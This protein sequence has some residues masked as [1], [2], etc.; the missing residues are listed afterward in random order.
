MTISVNCQSKQNE[1]QTIISP[2]LVDTVSQTSFLIS[3]T[4]SEKLKAGIYLAFPDT[5]KSKGLRL[6]NKNEYYFLAEK[7][8]VTL[9]EIDSV[10]KEFH[11]HI[12]RY[13]LIVRFNETSVKKWFDF[14]T[15]YTGMKVG[16]ILK[17]QLYHIAT[18]ASPIS[19]GETVLTNASTEKEIDHFKE[20]IENEIR[21]A[22]GL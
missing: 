8:A 6:Q 19:S 4:T 13:T 12:E 20:L 21:R 22:K 16:F 18:I 15:R 9:N 1:S 14:T 5:S 10:Y 2:S 7:P 11:P 17:E 3:D